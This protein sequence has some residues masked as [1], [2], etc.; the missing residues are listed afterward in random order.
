MTGGWVGRGLTGGWVRRG[1]TDGW[2]RRGLT[3]GW[4]KRGFICAWLVHKKG[5]NWVGEEVYGCEG[6][7][8]VIE[9]EWMGSEKVGLAR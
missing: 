1:L 4:V 8:S 5:F 2:V 9:K 6:F 7:L 3:G